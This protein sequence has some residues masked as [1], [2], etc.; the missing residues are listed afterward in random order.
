MAKK[1]KIFSSSNVTNP[2][3]KNFNNTTT[4]QQYI[5]ETNSTESTKKLLNSNTNQ[6][7]TNKKQTPN[8]KLTTQPTKGIRSSKSQNT[9]SPNKSP[10]I[11]SQHKLQHN[12]SHQPS[13]ANPTIKENK[14]T[15]LKKIPKPH[16]KKNTNKYNT[17]PHNQSNT[18][19]L[20]PTLTSQH[21]KPGNIKHKEQIG[22]QKNQELLTSENKSETPSNTS[23]LTNPTKTTKL[24]PKTTSYKLSDTEMFEKLI[25]K[26]YRHN[27]RKGLKQKL[28]FLPSTNI[29]MQAQTYSLT[30]ESCQTSKPRL[31]GTKTPMKLPQHIIT[32]RVGPNNTM[33]TFTDNKGNV[34]IQMSAGKIQLR[35]SRKNYK[36]ICHTVITE[37]FNKIKKTK[38][39]KNIL[40]KLSVPKNLKYKIMKRVKYYA[41]PKKESF[42]ELLRLLP[43]NGCRPPKSKRKKRQGLRIYKNKL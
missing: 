18:L 27:Y 3:N 2:K 29:V 9:N 19:T 14:P 32:I 31:T 11:N 16:N 5:T 17:N 26:A 37:F 8:P 10:N 43:F 4:T 13:T 38:I 39:K 41:R 12:K 22:T 1:K 30:N 20:Q 35:S 7:L 15:P 34:L 25:I 40:V 6:Q 42:Y 33:A 23:Q 24:T 36:K 21:E 28:H